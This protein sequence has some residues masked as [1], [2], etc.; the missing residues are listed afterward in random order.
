MSHEKS[1]F[2]ASHYVPGTNGLLSPFDPGTRN[3]SAGYQV[4][5]AFGP[6]S[7][8]I[9]FEKDVAVTLRDGV[10]IYV[11]VFRPAGSAF[12]S[13]ATP[14]RTSAR[15]FSRRWHATR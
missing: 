3:L 7:T 4:A 12:S 2:E 6:L 10:R 15:T 1:L 5:P 8:D 13:T 14:A 11:D 9:V